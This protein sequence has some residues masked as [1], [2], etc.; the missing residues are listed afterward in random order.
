MQATYLGDVLPIPSVSPVE[1]TVDSDSLTIT[2]AGQPVTL[3]RDEVR[4]HVEKRLTFDPRKRRQGPAFFGALTMAERR[5]EPTM[6]EVAHIDTPRGPVILAM[7]NVH[8]FVAAF[9]DS[10]Q[11][12]TA[13]AVPIRG[14]PVRRVIAVAILVLIALIIAVI[15]ARPNPH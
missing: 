7:E 12:A 14:R 5:G 4:V 8:A 1:V 3:P 10:R 9:T 15:I 11:A 2:H 6:Q 13:R